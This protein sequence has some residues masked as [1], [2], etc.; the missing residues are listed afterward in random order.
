MS[1]TSTI[2]ANNRLHQVKLKGQGL[3]AHLVGACTSAKLSASTSQITE[4][5]FT[6]ADDDDLA[7]F[8]RGTFAIGTILTY[9]KWVGRV[10]AV[11]LKPENAGPSVKVRAPSRYVQRLQNQTGEQNWGS[12]PVTRWVQQCAQSA[13]MKHI[14][15]PDIGNRQIV[16]E[17]AE[18]DNPD[19]TWDVMTQL[20]RE[21]GRLLFEYGDTLIFARPTWLASRAGRRQIRLNWKNWNEYSEGMDGMPGFKDAA[22]RKDQEL[23]VGLTSADADTFRPGDELIL[24]GNMGRA[25]GSWMVTKVD[26]SLSI[27][28]PVKLTCKRF[29]NPTP[30]PTKDDK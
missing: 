18:G 1:T 17:K 29:V 15:E 21:T 13:G 22:Q 7:I 25:N 14:V 11:E 19:S 23:T 24:E 27:T 4:L 8:R 6:F 16:R 30:E 26:F 12:Y 10:T 9:D 28:K 5:D 20:A 2:G 3:Q